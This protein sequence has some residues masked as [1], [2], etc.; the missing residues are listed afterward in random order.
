MSQG[1]GF[2]GASCSG[3]G[4]VEGED[5]VAKP[6]VPD[7]AISRPLGLEDE[8]PRRVPFAPVTSALS[9]ALRHLLLVERVDGLEG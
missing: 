5:I 6:P 1:R 3:G 4:R 2:H 7:S 9:Q 8:E